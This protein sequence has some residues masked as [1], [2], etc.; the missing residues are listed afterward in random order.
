[1]LRKYWRSDGG[2]GW[3]CCYRIPGMVSNQKIE[4]YSRQVAPAARKTLGR[5][6]KRAWSVRGQHKNLLVHAWVWSH[7]Q[8]KHSHTCYH[9]S[10]HT[11]THTQSPSSILSHLGIVTSATETQS[12]ITHVTTHLHTHIHKAHP[13]FYHAWVLSHLQQKHSHTSHM[14]PHIYTHTYKAHP[15]F[16]HAWVLSHLQQKHSHT[17]H[18]LPHIYTHT[19]THTHKAHPLFYHAWVLSH[20][21]Q[22]HSHTCYH[23]STHT[24]TKPI[25]SSIMLGYCHSCIRNTVT[26]HTCYHTSTHTQSPSSLLSCLGIVTSATETQ[27]H[28]THMLPQSSNKVISNFDLETTRSR[29][30]VRSKVKVT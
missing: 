12:H 26:H 7:L 5:A 21:Q 13:L 27:A 2:V 16:Y 3:S 22:K 18:M 25:L 15:L 23:T 29:S 28:I 17:S 9:T 8:Q 4:R 10:T 30:W 20:L 11:H 6:E 24:H 19:H 1:M 14:L